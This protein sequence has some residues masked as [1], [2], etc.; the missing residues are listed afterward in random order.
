M[1]KRPSASLVSGIVL[2]IGAMCT[3]AFGEI[4]DQTFGPINVEQY[5]NETGNL[6]VQFLDGLYFVTTRGLNS[7]PHRVYIFDED[8]NGVDNFVQHPIAQADAWGYRDGATDGTYLYFAVG[9]GIYR[10]D[11]DGSNPI[12]IIADGG[13]SGFH[14]ALAYD[15]TGDAGAGSFWTG[16]FSESLIEIDMEGNVL[17][18]F[19]D[20][21]AWSLY[22]LEWDPVTGNL[23]A[24]SR[25][26]SIDPPKI[27]EID[28][29]TGR[30]TGVEFFT[31]IAGH[32]RGGL[33]GVPGGA[34]GS[35]NLWDLV[36]LVQDSPDFLAGFE[37]Y[38]YPE[39]PE[40]LDGDGV[41]GQA[42]LG[43]LLAAY[44]IDDGGDIDLDGD[45]DQADLGMLLAAYG[46]CPTP[47][48]MGSCCLWDG[49]CV[50]ATEFDCQML[51]GD[52][53]EGEECETFTCPPQPLGA[54]CAPDGSS[55]EDL[56]AYDCHLAGGDWYE[57]EACGTF[58]CP[59]PYCDASGGC[60]EYSCAEYI[61]NVQVGDIDNA[62]A[63]DGYG[64]FTYLTT[65]MAIGSDYEIT[66]TLTDSYV[67]D[68]GGLWI[69]WNRDFDFDD[70]GEEITTAWSGDGP[71]TAVVT[72]PAG[73]ELGQTR[74][75]IR[76]TWSDAPQ[77]C[78]VTI[79]GEV[80]DYT[81]IVSPP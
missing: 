50:N 34:G 64:D 38:E 11:A 67:N 5:T 71:Y 4:G 27:I 33:T 78:G 56:T 60:A 43:I 13:P 75:R 53:H 40:D 54:C 37:I 19:Q 66:I 35:G 47:D 17:T 70:A 42:D 69:D 77:S 24:H 57:G 59:Q 9:A 28:A 7:P 14:R 25:D 8:G 12:Q 68:R 79:F 61:S 18:V 23:W 29:T 36:G 48:A 1:S 46:P 52:W 76:L 72:P 32:V 31:S 39:C 55:C 81:V 15:P 45:T 6:G 80:E 22:G 51:A 10:H 2:A 21:D 49:S 26:G 58:T 73:T 3:A 20:L 16:D 41:V 74:M 62:S 63:C 30:T 44:D 65:E